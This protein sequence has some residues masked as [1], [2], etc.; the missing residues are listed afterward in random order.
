MGTLPVSAEKEKVLRA[1]MRGLG[2][3]E[4]EIEE[5]FV[6]SGGPG[7]QNV[8]KTS[9]CVR[10]H[11]TPSGLRVRCTR[12]RAQGLNRYHARVSLCDKM[13]RKLTGA[14]EA[15]R[16]RVEKLRRQKRRRSRRAKEKVLQAKRHTSEKK[17]ARS[18]S[19]ASEP[20]E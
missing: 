17:K 19:F 13:E 6:R 10:L 12:T 2:L 20:D 4:A 3:R 7:G 15:E 11:H 16:K 8:N 14:V 9:T 1:R 18:R 5:T